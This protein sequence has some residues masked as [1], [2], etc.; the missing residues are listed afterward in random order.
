LRLLRKTQFVLIVPLVL[1]LLALLDWRYYRVGGWW[2]RLVPPLLACACFG[3]WTLVQ[4]QFL[5]PGSFLANLAQTRQAAGGA[6]FVFDRDATLRA[7]DYLAQVYGGLFLPALAYGLWRCRA[8]TPHA[9][10][11]LLLVLLPAVWL[12]WYVISLGWPRYAFPAVVFG[13]LAVARL[14]RDLFVGLMALRL[15]PAAWLVVG[16]AALVVVV[17][18]L[19]SARLVFSPDRSAQT[20]A[21]YLDARVPQTALIETWEQEL[22][23]LTDHRYHY[24]P[25]ELLDRAVR[26]TWLDGA[27]LAY[28]GLA[29]QPPYVVVGPFGA[30][31]QIYDPARLA[32]EYSAEFVAG[33]YRLYR[34]NP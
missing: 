15:R 25:I 19:L 7:L 24:P 3:V 5:G 27:T 21:A 18:L 8:R 13:A 33:P 12:C 23:L 17:P 34:R 32:T 2:L 10:C 6:I 20:F 22:G 9:L 30:W 31:V 16:Y 11:E 29:A 28:D 1:A 26:Q 4:L 14:L